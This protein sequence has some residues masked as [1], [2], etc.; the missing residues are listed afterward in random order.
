M[1]VFHL[2]FSQSAGC[3]NMMDGEKGHSGM[4]GGSTT[5]GNSEA[6]DGNHCG[7]MGYDM[8]SMMGSKGA[9]TKSMM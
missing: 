9:D 8:D 2:S 1:Q 5:S 3:E 7:D 6:E 4:M